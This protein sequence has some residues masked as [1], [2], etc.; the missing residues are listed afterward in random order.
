M[1]RV[2]SLFGGGADGSGAG[3][4][5]AG[6]RRSGGSLLDELNLRAPR[7]RFRALSNRKLAAVGVE[8]PHW[9][10]AVARYARSFSESRG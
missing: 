7:P 8:M 1:L 2:E 9:R 5:G 4:P 3:G 6:G 10:D